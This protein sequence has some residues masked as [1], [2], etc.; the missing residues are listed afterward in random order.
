MHSVSMFESGLWLCNMKADHFVKTN[1]TEASDGG[2][3]KYGR[4]IVCFVHP[5]GIKPVQTGCVGG[6]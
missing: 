6:C 4:L 2:L 3:Q 5:F 1:E